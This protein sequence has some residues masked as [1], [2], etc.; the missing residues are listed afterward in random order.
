MHQFTNEDKANAPAS[1]TYGND[2]EAVSNG[3][4]C[5]KHLEEVGYESQER[6]RAHIAHGIGSYL[7]DPLRL[8]RAYPK[9]FQTVLREFMTKPDTTVSLIQASI[10]RELPLSE[11]YPILHIC[12]L[13]LPRVKSEYQP[14][15]L[16]PP[17]EARSINSIPTFLVLNGQRYLLA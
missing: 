4:L 12:A 11:L 2:P 14:R 8:A 1:K 6:G 9:G 15:R 5:R 16:Q 17:I 10:T 3:H 7:V 13:A